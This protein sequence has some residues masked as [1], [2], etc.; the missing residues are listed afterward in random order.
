V[1]LDVSL[2]HFMGFI[3]FS[4]KIPQRIGFDYK[5]RGKM[6]NYRIPLKGY[7]DKHVVE[8][9]M[10]LLK[11]LDI[12]IQT[13]NLEIFPSQEDEL[14]ADH[15]LSQ[16]N[17]SGNKRL[18]GLVPGGGASWGKDAGFKRWEA[19]NYAKLA[20]NLIENHNLTIILLGDKA[21]ESLCEAVVSFMRHPC[22][23]ACGKTTVHQF[24]SLARKCHGMIVNDGGPLHISVAA[25]ARTV[26]IFGPVDEKVYGPYPKDQH[27]VVSK[28]IACRPCYRR[29]RRASC[30]HISC[31]KT[32]TVE[33][34]LERVVS[35]L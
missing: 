28:D 26:S 16:N 5:G 21:E 7:E 12:P 18:M 19:Q 15:F 25:G 29:F 6:L 27:V 13:R 35:I 33:E 30:D 23:L 10:D 4:A 34:V 3:S 8:Y 31:L 1:V 11:V 14:W 17:L 9:Y 20:D 32:I 22:I 24:A 2:N